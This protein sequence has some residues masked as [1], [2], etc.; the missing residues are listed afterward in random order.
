M[1][2]YNIQF[3]PN[4]LELTTDMLL[5]MTDALFKLV[6]EP[7]ESGR[8]P[9]PYLLQKVQRVAV[10]KCSTGQIRLPF[11]KTGQLSGLFKLFNSTF[12]VQKLSPA[13]ESNFVLSSC[14]FE[15]YLCME[16]VL[17]IY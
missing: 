7:R 4:R 2:K 9:L 14:F 8:A 6:L 17:Q 5:H 1:N 3:N 12:K 11:S 13:A 16:S 15:H 10:V